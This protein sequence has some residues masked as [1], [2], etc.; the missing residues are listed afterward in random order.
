MRL[1]DILQSF[2]YTFE[3]V[4]DGSHNSTLVLSSLSAQLSFCQKL[5]K[6]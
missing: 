1:A 5:L 2:L 6:S 3:S 4:E